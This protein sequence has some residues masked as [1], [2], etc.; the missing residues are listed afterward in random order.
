VTFVA[1]LERS[2]GR[3]RARA[4]RPRGRRLAAPL[5]RSRHGFPHRLVRLYPALS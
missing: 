1:R 4:A 5:L 2:T 3:A